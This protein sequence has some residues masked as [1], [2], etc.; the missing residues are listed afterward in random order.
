MYLHGL[1]PV[2]ILTLSGKDLTYMY[3]HALI[4]IYSKHITVTDMQ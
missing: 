1:K 2:L 3:T 4:L